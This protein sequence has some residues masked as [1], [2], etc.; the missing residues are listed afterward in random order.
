MIYATTG[1]LPHTRPHTTAPFTLSITYPTRRRFLITAGGS[2]LITAAGCAGGDG[3]TMDS[4]P[5]SAAT[6]PFTDLRGT[7]VQ[8]PR[9]PERVVAL[10]DTNVTRI[11]LSLGVRPI[12]SV[13]RDGKLERVSGLYDVSGIES[14]GEWTEPN[15]E[16][17]AQLQPDLII[18]YG[19]NGQPLPDSLPVK[20]LETI[21]PTI[22]IDSF[23]S[24]AEVMADYG[25]VFN[26]ETRVRQ[27]QAAYEA[28]IAEVKQAI[29]PKLDQLTVSVISNYQ[30]D[31]GTIN[32][33]GNQLILTSAVL[34]D[35]GVAGS[36]AEQGGQTP[37]SLELLPTV[38]ADVI[39]V[40]QF[41]GDPSYTTEPLYQTLK[42]VQ[43]GQVYEV[44]GEAWGVRNYDGLNRVL[45]GLEEILINADPNVFP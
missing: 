12:G 37:I 18:G 27:Q 30:L 38:D 33:Y 10:H 13:V 44:D 19:N 42:A 14:I 43:A 31:E 34:R 35:L 45:D 22:F 20:Q 16:R 17:I 21:A 1:T 9:Q 40:V 29:A 11:M 8:I 36:A 15:L 32:V 2:I 5:P 25:S 4:P 39:I 7:T 26:L 3:A 24:V 28:R 23:R 41:A 6:K